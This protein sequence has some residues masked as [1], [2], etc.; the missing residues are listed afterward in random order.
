MGSERVMPVYQCVSGMPDERFVAQ[1]SEL[2]DHVFGGYGP[3]DIGDVRWVL[4]R[5]PDVTIQVASDGEQLVGFKIGYAETQKRYYSYLGGVR[6][7]F[8]VRGIARQL[9]IHQHDWVTDHGFEGIETGATNTNV[10]MIRLNLSLGFRVI[11]SYCRTDLPRIRL[12]K[13]L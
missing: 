9:A 8:R 2:C 6:E 1:L 12:Y 13:H 5:M 4:S 3:S 11:G 7:S 10:P